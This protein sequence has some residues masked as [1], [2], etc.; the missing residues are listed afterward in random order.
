MS[1]FIFMLT[2]NDQ[3][4]INAREVY[5]SIRH[6]GL[7]YVGFKDI[8]LPLEELKLLAND[9]RHDGCKVMLEVVSSTQDSE[10][11]SVEAAIEL[12]VDYLL[13]GR[14]AKEAVKLLKKCDI[15][16]FPFAGHT[17]GHPTKLTGSVQEIVEDAKQL[18]ALDGVHGLDLLAYRFAGNVPDLAQQVVQA[19]KKPVIAA[20]SIDRPERIQAMRAAGM[21]AFTVGSALFDGLFPA[22]SMKAQVESVLELEGVEV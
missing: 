22:N 15:Q 7:R 9:I 18:C 8:G 11:R 3:T 1:H 19:V 20:G 13:G 14:H 2:R 17:V 4:V 12:R 21:W 5:Q 16:Y 6:C 10:L